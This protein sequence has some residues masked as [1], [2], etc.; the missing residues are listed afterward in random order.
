MREDVEER[1][2]R[3]ATILWR[4]NRI[5]LRLKLPR[6]CQVVL[7]VKMGLREGKV[8]GSEEPK[9]KFL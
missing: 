3:V 9:L 6:P 8:L 4:G 1:V 2:V 5:F 7:L